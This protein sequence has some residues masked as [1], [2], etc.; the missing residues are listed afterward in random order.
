MYVCVLGY[1]CSLICFFYSFLIYIIFMS[2]S[3]CSHYFYELLCAFFLSLSMCFFFSSRRRHTRCALVTG[4]QTCALPICRTPEQSPVPELAR[5]T[6]L[7]GIS[8]RNAP[9]SER[10]S[11]K[12]PSGC[13]RVGSDMAHDEAIGVCGKGGRSIPAGVGQPPLLRSEEHTS[14]L[15]S[16]MRISYAGFCLQTK[17]YDTIHTR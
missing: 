7:A 16:L 2:R 9:F 4:V 14:E 13:T 8:Q 5:V 1:S 3:V 17:Q 15:Q 11:A 10:R 6:S 12:Y